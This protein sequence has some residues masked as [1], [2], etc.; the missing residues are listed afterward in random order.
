MIVTN[1][2]LCDK[3][4]QALNSCVNYIQI[5]LD[6]C[7]EIKHANVDNLKGDIDIGDY[8]TTLDSVSRILVR[9]K[10]I[11]GANRGGKTT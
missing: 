7:L 3:T 5:K 8:I 11:E 1:E 9:L 6:K 2:E 10:E 4:R